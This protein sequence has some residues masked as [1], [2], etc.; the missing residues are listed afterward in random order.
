MY[1]DLKQDNNINLI[2]GKICYRELKD[3]SVDAIEM[4]DD[5]SGFRAFISG[6][7][8]YKDIDTDEVMA[9]RNIE[10]K[11]VTEDNEE[12]IRL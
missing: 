6:Q 7:I 12:C 1:E 11:A 10:G 4:D 5:Y 9:I 3:A 2:D 8:V